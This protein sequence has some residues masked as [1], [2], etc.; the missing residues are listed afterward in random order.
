MVKKISAE[1]SRSTHVQGIA[2][3]K[4]RKYMY[5]SFTTSLVKTDMQG[6]VVGSVKGL[7]G[8]LGCIAYNEED[9][10]VYGSLEYKHDSIGKGIL[11]NH[12]DIKDVEDGFYIA[13][14]DVD[15]ID[16]EDMDACGVMTAVY[17]KEVFDDFSAPCHRYGCS[18]IDGTTI[19]PAVGEK[20]GEKFLYVAY[21]I[22]GD[23]ERNDNDYQ[24]ILC[25]NL[26]ELCTYEK[27]LDQL[28]MHR[29]GP[30]KYAHKYFVY[31]GN[32]TWGVQNLEYD[33]HLGRFIAAVYT[34]KK[35][36]FPNFPM[37]MIDVSKPAE[38]KKLCGM[39]EC[40]EVLPLA[41]DG[42]FDERSGV[43]GFDFKYGATGMISLGNG[44]YYFSHPWV[45]KEKGR[46]GSDVYLYRYDEKDGFVIA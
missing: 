13:T 10:R 19:A 33:A 16:R 44:C 3:D 38:T 27:P 17:L 4:E 5:F 22:Y 36:Q 8:H 46:A 6:N 23:T 20:S 11:E 32:T 7:A 41:V 39:D 40:G 37:F 43:Y 24:V 18:G 26:K 30:A 34:G 29:S 35:E 2:V 42:I 31:T 28:S 45:D 14:F 12:S 1:I 21:G 9:G 15:K 25:Y